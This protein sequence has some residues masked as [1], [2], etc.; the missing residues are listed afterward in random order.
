M[1]LAKNLKWSAVFFLFCVARPVFSYDWPASGKTGDIENPF[2]MLGFDPSTRELSGYIKAVRIAP[3]RT[4]ECRVVFSG[5]LTKTDVFALGYPDENDSGTSVQNATL[6]MQQGQPVLRIKKPIAQA[7]CEWILPFVGEP[8]IQ[9]SSEELSLTLGSMMPGD[10]LGVYSIKS[11]RAYFYRT[12]DSSSI[13]VP[14][15][16]KGDVIR[17]YKWAGPWCYVRYEKRGRTT[18]GWLKKSDLLLQ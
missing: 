3:G 17:V 14:F 15:V 11:P 1:R 4:D 16:V 5:N 8:R 7:D 12:P 13:Q 2:I 10:W 6:I 18:E 9:E